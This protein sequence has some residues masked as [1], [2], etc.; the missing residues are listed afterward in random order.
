MLKEYIIYKGNAFWSIEDMLKAYYKNKND[1]DDI[2]F[3]YRSS[4]V[5]LKFEYDKDMSL[6]EQVENYIKFIDK[7]YEK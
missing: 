7:N 3:I 1:Y 4:L 5:N 2:L 6:Y